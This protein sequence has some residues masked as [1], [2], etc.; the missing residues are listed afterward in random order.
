MIGI[1]KIYI[2]RFF[3]NDISFQSITVFEKNIY[4]FRFLYLHLFTCFIDLFNSINKLRKSTL[5]LSKEIF[6]Y[7]R[8]K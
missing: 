4:F 8:N 3:V 6:L 7:V 1:S 2:C 5:I